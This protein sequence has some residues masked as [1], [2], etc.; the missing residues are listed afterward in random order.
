M[1]DRLVLNLVKN[2]FV[3]ADFDKIVLKV[4][5]FEDGEVSWS[6]RNYSGILTDGQGKRAASQ[7]AINRALSFHINQRVNLKA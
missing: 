4:Y 7:G 2:D 3:V 1:P 5:T 6:I